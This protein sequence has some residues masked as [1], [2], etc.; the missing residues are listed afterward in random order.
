M[1]AFFLPEPRFF[2][3]VKMGDHTGGERVL[4]GY[5]H[6]PPRMRSSLMSDEGGKGSD[7]EPRNMIICEFS[8]PKGPP[9]VLINPWSWGAI[10][11]SFMSGGG[12]LIR[13][14]EPLSFFIFF[15]KQIYANK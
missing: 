4:A 9:T 10:S 5:Y 6:V 13:S 1:Y 2:P 3:C 11:L 15:G 14:Y 12:T 8:E 7:I